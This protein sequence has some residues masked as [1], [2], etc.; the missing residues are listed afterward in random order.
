MDQANALIDH[1]QAI[2]LGPTM[3]R[4][5]LHTQINLH[6]VIYGGGWEESTAKAANRIYNNIKKG[7]YIEINIWKKK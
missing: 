4:C 5:E 3:D 2:G 7:K 6:H 1:Y